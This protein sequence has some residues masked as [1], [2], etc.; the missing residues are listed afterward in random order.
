MCIRDRNYGITP[1]TSDFNQDGYPDLVFTNISGPV[2]AHINE[3][4]DANYIALRLPE[5]AKYLGAIVT[6]T[7][8]DGST[9]TDTYVIGE[10]LASDQT[11][12]LTFGLGNDTS[13]RGVKVSLADGSSFDLES[14]RVNQLN[15]L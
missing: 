3:G 6:V 14:P 7:K 1:L 2:Q 8:N 4:G 15:S 13:V 5:N 9:L 10:G 12:T 11:S